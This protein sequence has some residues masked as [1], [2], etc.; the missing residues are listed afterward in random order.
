L[1]EAREAFPRFSLLE[2]TDLEAVLNGSIDKELTS[3]MFDAS[4]VLEHEVI[5]G[6]ISRQEEVLAFDASVTYEHPE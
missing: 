5:T 6:M 4:L 3:R 1:Q 2:D